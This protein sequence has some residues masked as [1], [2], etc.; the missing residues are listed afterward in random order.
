MPK[1]EINNLVDGET[2]RVDNGAQVNIIEKI[3]VNGDVLRIND[4]KEINIPLAS[5]ED[6]NQLFVEGA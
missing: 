4:N 3:S 5:E 2:A 6:I 1:L